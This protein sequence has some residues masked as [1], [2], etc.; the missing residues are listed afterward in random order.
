MSN[1]MKKIDYVSLNRRY[2]GI[3]GISVL[4]ALVKSEKFC[5]KVAP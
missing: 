3:V 4:I 1:V 5:K 2:Y